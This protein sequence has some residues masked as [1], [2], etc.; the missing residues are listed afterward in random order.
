MDA[1]ST[2]PTRTSM[3]SWTG[4][5][6]GASSAMARTATRAAGTR[7]E[8]R[9]AADARRGAA[10]ARECMARKAKAILK[11]RDG[12]R[13]GQRRDDAGTCR[14]H[15]GERRCVAPRDVTSSDDSRAKIDVR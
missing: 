5:P 7:A 3:S 6:S 12:R 15:H 4:G 2:L 14:H 9:R 13:R 10:A 1:L 8:T 11:E